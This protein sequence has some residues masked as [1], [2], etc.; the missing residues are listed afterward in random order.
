MA[1]S[2]LLIL[3]SQGRGGSGW[4]GRGQLEGEIEKE[5]G[6]GGEREGEGGRVLLIRTLV[7]L[8]YGPTLRTPFNLNS[9]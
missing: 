7:L 4:E 3:S 2:R 5:E 6:G 1:E 8:A 9:S